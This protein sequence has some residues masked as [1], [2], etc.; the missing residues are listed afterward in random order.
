MVSFWYYRRILHT[1]AKR[2]EQMTTNYPHVVNVRL[3]KELHKAIRKHMKRTDEPIQHRAII[4]L[5]KEGLKN[6]EKR[7]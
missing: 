3:S 7:Q 6:K 1:S 2:K 4:D 5:L